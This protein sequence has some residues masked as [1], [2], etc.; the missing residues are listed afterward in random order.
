VQMCI[1]DLTIQKTPPCVITASVRSCIQLP[2]WMILYPSHISPPLF[3][4]EVHTCWMP[5]SVVVYQLLLFVMLFFV[6]TSK[7]AA[8]ISHFISNQSIEKLHLISLIR[9]LHLGGCFLSD[10]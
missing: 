1:S 10:I 6:V 5:I 3:V 8:P 2:C 7:S 9:K 4:W